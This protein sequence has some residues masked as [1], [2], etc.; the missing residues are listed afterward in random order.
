MTRQL[1]SFALAFVLLAFGLTLACGVA[2]VGFSP[3]FAEEPT[4]RGARLGFVARIPTTTAH[5]GN[6]CVNWAGS[7]ART[8]PLKLATR[9]ATWRGFPC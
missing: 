8:S 5:C 1:V 4:Q 2:G 9:K 7:K 3:A 6:A